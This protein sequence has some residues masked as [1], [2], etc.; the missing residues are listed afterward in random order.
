MSDP[1][2][3]L[4]R[5][6]R[7]QQTLLRELIKARALL[8]VSA[9]VAPE[10][11]PE[12]E[13]SPLEHAPLRLQGVSQLLQLAPESDQLALEAPNNE[14]LMRRLA[15]GDELRVRASLRGV[16]LFFRTVFERLHE[17]A[18]LQALVCRWPEVVDYRQRRGAFRVAIPMAMEARAHWCLDEGTGDD[19]PVYS[20]RPADV[21]IQGLGLDC[22][23]DAGDV[24]EPGTGILIRTL[25]MGG[26][27]WSDLP[28]V[29][30]NI[31]PDPRREGRCRL[32]LQ[33]SALP[34]AAE[35]TLNRLIMDLQQDAAK[36]V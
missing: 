22:E 20:G 21:S 1:S 13:E 31:K 25:E 26:Y 14:V 29:V 27:H 34:P 36:R 35:R 9:S 3:S 7:R 2:A 23:L 19:Q 6:R 18:D 32:G 12:G 5:N 4:I 11:V 28:A 16:P 24:P 30:R 8:T 15:P 17:E 33:F 10:P